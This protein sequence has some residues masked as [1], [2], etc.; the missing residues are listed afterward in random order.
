M[1]SSTPSFFEVVIERF[2]AW[3][4][5]GGTGWGEGAWQRKEDNL[6]AGKDVGGGTILPAVWVF[7]GDRFI[8][9][10]G[11]KDDVWDAVACL[12]MGHIDKRKD[13]NESTV[14]RSYSLV[15]F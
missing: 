3:S 5:D 10:T 14:H 15:F 1:T 2:I 8:A 6:F 13:I 7:T 9:D 4:V 11:F 12:Q